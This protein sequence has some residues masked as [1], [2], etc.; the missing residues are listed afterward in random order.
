MGKTK[1]F[2]RRARF[3]RDVMGLAIIASA[4][5]VGTMI[6]LSMRV[7]KDISRQYIQDAGRRVKEHYRAIENSIER[8]LEMACQSGELGGLLLSKPKTL[9]SQLLP[10][11]KREPLLSGISL[12]DESG[13]SY[14][15]QRDGTE[16]M[17]SKS[18]GFDPRTR[19]WF[20]PAL[21]EEKPYWTK[22]YLFHTLKQIGITASKSFTTPSG[23]KLVLAFDVL[24]SDF[25]SKIEKMV[26]S[27]GSNLVFFRQDEMLIFSSKKGSAPQFV[28]V[29][30][31]GADSLTE[32]AYLRWTQKDS[33]SDRIFDIKQGGQTWWCSFYPLE[34]D[35]KITWIGIMV[36][37][38][39]I[40]EA[41]GDRRSTLFFVGG[42]LVLLLL[43][44]A[45]GV[46]RRYARVLRE[47]FR[48][49]STEEGVRALIQSGENRFVEFKSTMR[50]NLH[51]KKPGKEIEV[52]WLKG[53][54]AFL[55]TDGGTLLLGVT[56]DGEILGLE[57]DVFENDDKCRLHFKNLVATHLG[58]EFSKYIRFALVPVDG[59]TV[60]MIHCFR[61]SDPVFLKVGNKESF[62][63]RNGPSSDELPVSK[64]IHYIEARK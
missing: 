6:Y 14:F 33:S 18:G 64:V 48:V 49:E 17:P 34:S 41:A 25:Y 62:Y 2:G 57:K 21:K 63:I 19:P 50:M 61:T 24:L 12:A 51:T 10:F 9:K 46:T 38:K 37:E 1:F 31:S 15:L 32:H 30:E 23:K 16:R 8:S 43:G 11:F 39:D 59:K 4:L 47:E 44:S 3:S 54:A 60:G 27:K 52:A 36:P 22:Q 45:W 58:A 28:P 29:K 53:V 20:A 5:L 35:R 56:D 42:G 13:A 7:K 40:L 26:P 55:N